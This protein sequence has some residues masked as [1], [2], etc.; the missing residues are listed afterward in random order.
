MKKIAIVVLNWKQA[1]LTIDTVDSL[2]KISHKKFQYQILIIDNASPD[3]S[4]DQFE[5]KYS[6]NKNVSIFKTNSNLGYAG[7]NNFGIKKALNKFNYILIANNDILVDPKFLDKLFEESQ[8][9]S[10][11]ILTPKIYFAPGFEYW[12]DKYTAKERGKVIW[13]IGGK[14]DWN[15]VYGSNIGID[16]VDHGQYDKNHPPMDFISGCCFLIPTKILKK[17]GLFDEKYFLYMEDADLTIR[18]KSAGY[19]LKFVPESIIWHLNSGSSG[20]NSS[21]QDYF[22]TRNRLIFAFRFVS[23]RTKFALIRESIRFLFDKNSSKWRK[24]A[25]IDFYINKTGKGSWK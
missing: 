4:V 21:L 3:D 25:I 5:K 9:N 20:P 10:N 8:K 1:K 18:A 11:A 22:I 15:N 16:E 14:I 17:I 2:L 23:L 6:N 24:Q 12:K 19:E 13:A 7:G